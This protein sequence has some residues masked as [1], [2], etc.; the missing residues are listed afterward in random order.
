MKLSAI[1]PRTRPENP[2]EPPRDAAEPRHRPLAA[3]D[4]A[5]AQTRLADDRLLR[6]LLVNLGPLG[7]PLPLLDFWRDSASS[8]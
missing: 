2:A 1:L 5:A 4:S 7:V 6:H 3:G 8:R